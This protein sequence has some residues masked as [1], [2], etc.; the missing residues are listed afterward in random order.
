[1]KKNT[2]SKIGLGIFVS[3]AIAL[4]IVGIYF[5]G[6]KQQMFVKTFTIKAVF[7]DVSGLQIGNNVRFSGIVVGTVDNIQIISD[8]SVRVDIVIDETVRKFIKKDAKA[9]IGTDGLMGNKILTITA[10]TKDE[11]QIEDY[12]YILTSAPIS[13]DDI[14]KQLKI[15]SE[16]ASQITGDMAIIM[17]TIRSGKGTVG[18]LFM[19]TAFADNVDQTIVNLKQGTGGFKQ[20]MDAAK[21][22][23]FFR[24]FF[25]K[26]KKKEE[27]E[28]IKKEKAKEEA[29][30]E[31]GKKSKNKE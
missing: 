23:I 18:K 31:E 11:K 1:M 2:G 13:M 12:D 20:N 27:Q 15:T 28:R 14:L 24:G 7:K 25:K 26:K 30:E 4:F 19:D 3:V 8:S 10:G 6:E 21:E 22:N 29:K 16:N 5:I 9:V 17:S